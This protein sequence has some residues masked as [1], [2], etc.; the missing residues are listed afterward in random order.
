[1]AL[2]KLAASRIGLAALLAGA[3]ALSACSS[4]GG[5]A[6]G[7]NSA[8]PPTGTASLGGGKA[9]PGTEIGLS[10]K[11]IRI[12]VIADVDTSVAPGLFQKSVNAVKAWAD[13]VNANGGLAGRKV[14]VDFY[15]SKHTATDARNAVIQAC[16]KDFALVGT[17]ALNLST[18]TDLDTCK[19]AQGH[20]LGIP[21]LAG[22]MIGLQTCDKNTYSPDT[23]HLDPVY[24]RTIK[25]KNPSHTEQ[26]GD[27]K[28]LLSQFPGLH[29]IFVNN[30][31]VPAIK[32]T[33]IAQFDAAVK[34]GIKKDGAG[35]YGAALNEPQSALTPMVQVIKRYN[36]T[37]VGNAV[38]PASL[39]LMIREA[40]LQGVNSVKV[41]SCSAACYSNDFIKQGGSAADGVY[42]TLST[43]P[44]Y[45]EYE[46]N[47]ALK[48]L[49][50]KLGGTDKIDQNAL[51]SYVSALL[52]EDAVKKAAASGSLS[53]ASLFTALKTQ[54][55]SFDAEGIV[56]PTNVSK[57]TPSPCF[58]LAQVKD[59]KWQRVHPTKVGTFDC[60]ASN[61]I[62]TK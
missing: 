53:R 22:I 18:L 29:G 55:T 47:P 10:A 42:N 41:W 19:D 17:E 61:L 36:S 28:W 32:K 60:K 16:S 7:S 57:R 21:N 48:A 4:S 40:Q 49:I 8:P 27:S 11:Q 35:Y 34:A 30:T 51:S 37:Y 58:V 2:T 56:G 5:G 33:Q 1:M 24:C 46:S 12:G 23:V 14:V 50:D 20:A 45:S 13:L 15:D 44:F 31:D 62:V 59:G 38:G 9:A 6:S 54:E 39:V 43:L 3:L 25:E 26:V 52:F